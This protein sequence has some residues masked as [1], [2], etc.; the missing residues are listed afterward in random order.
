MDLEDIREMLR[1]EYQLE[2]GQAENI[3]VLSRQECELTLSKKLN[4]LD[5]MDKRCLSRMI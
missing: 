4:K 2:L 1:E 5:K 3:A